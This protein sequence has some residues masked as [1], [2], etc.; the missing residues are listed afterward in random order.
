MYS[1]AALFLFHALREA[2]DKYIYMF[3]GARRAMP[4]AAG[5]MLS[6]RRVLAVKI[7]PRWPILAF[8]GCT[9]HCRHRARMATRQYNEGAECRR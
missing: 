1:S 7:I 3:Y 6:R 5:D 8:A 9:F 2:A 4:M